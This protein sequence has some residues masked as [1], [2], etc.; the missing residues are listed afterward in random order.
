MSP[1]RKKRSRQEEDVIRIVADAAGG[2]RIGT[3]KTATIVKIA[4]AAA[5]AEAVLATRAGVQTRMADAVGGQDLK[6][7]TEAFQPNSLTEI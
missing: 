1:K 4:M 6:V 3:G 2:V 5:I 7:Q